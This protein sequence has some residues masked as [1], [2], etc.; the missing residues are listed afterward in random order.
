MLTRLYGLL[1]CGKVS[2]TCNVLKAIENYINPF[3][4]EE[5]DQ[6]LYCISSGRIASDQVA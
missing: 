1:R 6:S 3:Q 5:F 2:K 4:Q